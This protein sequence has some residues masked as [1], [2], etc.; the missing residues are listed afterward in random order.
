MKILARPAF[1]NKSENPYNWLL[2]THIDALGVEVTE[3]SPYRLLR[4]KYDIWHIHWPEGG[5]MCQ[6]PFQAIRLSLGLLVL[7]DIAKLQGTKIVWTVHNLKS[8]ESLYS[9]LESWFWKSFIR[10]IDACIHLSQAGREMAFKSF[11]TLR[12][13]KNTV[14]PHGHYRDIYPNF[15]AKTEARQKLALPLTTKV[16]AFVG[17]IRPYKNIPRL[18]EVFRQLSDPQ[19][20]LLIAGFPYTPEI[21]KALKI[22]AAE[23]NRIHLYL[24][25]LS[26]NAMQLYLSAADLVALPYSQILNSGTALLSLSLNRP[27]LLPSQATFHELQDVVSKAWLRTYAGELT[28]T[29]IAA[30]L[31]W[32]LDAP[33][34]NVAHLEALNWTEIAQKTVDYF[35]TLNSNHKS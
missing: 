3:F 34:H 26:E 18:I 30:A 11:P 4:E 29:E 35:Q 32:S 16:I 17:Q 9:R 1:K 28:C 8:H 12:K 31:D 6:N 5:L 22:A 24:D 21:E 27:V 25:M 33:R 20:F 19:A 10:K 2:Y 14:V 23:D 7:I 15:I 13:Y